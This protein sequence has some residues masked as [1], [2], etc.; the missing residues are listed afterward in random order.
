MA[1]DFDEDFSD[2]LPD[3]A[4]VSKPAPR[5]H[6]LPFHIDG[7]D[8]LSP[9]GFVGQV[10]AWIDMQ[11]RYPRQRLAVAS[12][13]ATVGNIGGLRHI[14]ARDGVTANLLI[15][16][17]AASATGKEAVQ[18]AMAALHRSA[19]VHYALQGG[20]KSEQEIMRNLIEHQAAYY[21][22]DEIGIF[23]GK[24]RNAQRR[25]GAAYLEG[26]FGAI[27]S[28]Y[29]KASSR[30]L[31]QGDTK[32]ELRKMFGAM[33]SKAQD[34]GDDK[35]IA[36]MSR[37]LAM[38]DDGL[39]RPF[40]SLVGY[41]TPSTFDGIMDGETATQGF[42]G[43]ALIVTEP[44]INP[45][46][47]KA[48]SPPRD[49][50]DWMANK[51]AAIY[52]GGYCNHDAGGRIEWP[53][54]PEPVTTTPEASQMLDAV[55]DWLLAYAEDMGENTG[56]ASVAMI[57]RA[58]EAV[59]KV[60]FILAL[61][62]GVRGPEHVRWAFAYVRAELDG[63]IK[64]VFANDNAKDRPEESIAARV[65]GYIDPDKGTSLKVL[66]NRAKLKPEALAAVL[67]KM[68]AQGLVRETLSQK[69]YKGEF[70][71]IWAKVEGR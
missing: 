32:R 11:C 28:A 44:D 3:H 68:E 42:V 53:H 10:A 45:P 67:R 57:R 58:Y 23:L 30:L 15:F 63:K 47:R 71:P 27:M 52:S 4:K 49:V 24:V 66:A 13:L 12:A 16:C 17:V 18:Q 31:L 29:S 50:P 2:Y 6:D 65:L 9:P 41:T 19:A 34:D 35:A 55:A 1:S 14:D 43:R 36:R 70:A 54:D 46:A 20:I 40:L 51:L 60:S 39:D 33:L 26:V 22:V 62:T 38:V 59:A 69:R 48:F 61:D 21:I 25:G 64:L 8:L 37:M 5:K 56:E 7:C